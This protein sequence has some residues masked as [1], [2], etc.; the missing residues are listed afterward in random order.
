MSTQ[1]DQDYLFSQVDGPIYG[2]HVGGSSTFASTGTF[3]IPLTGT[4]NYSRNI[5]P[6]IPPAEPVT[7]MMNGA[8]FGPNAQQVGGTFFLGRPAGDVLMQDAFVGQQKRP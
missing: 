6:V 2:I 3:D 4:A 7:G 8:F 5:S 1:I